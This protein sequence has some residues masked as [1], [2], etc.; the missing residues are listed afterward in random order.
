MIA[1][2]VLAL[3]TIAHGAEINA[4]DYDGYYSQQGE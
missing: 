1:A 3:M 4:P 2:F